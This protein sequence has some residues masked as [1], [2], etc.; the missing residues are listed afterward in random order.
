MEDIPRQKVRKLRVK[1]L[2]LTSLFTLLY[3][4]KTELVLDFR[5]LRLCLSRLPFV[6][7][8]HLIKSSEVPLPIRGMIR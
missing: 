7:R 3:T 8:L 6:P 2:D 1:E 4:T 5:S